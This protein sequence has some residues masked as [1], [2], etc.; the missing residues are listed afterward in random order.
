[1]FGTE[2]R[3]GPA[4]VDRVNSPGPGNYNIDPVAFD[5]KKPRFHMGGSRSPSK[6]VTKVP[7]AGSYNPA[8]ESTKK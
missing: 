3:K 7:G 5:A 1:M 2:R 8:H 6:E 4:G